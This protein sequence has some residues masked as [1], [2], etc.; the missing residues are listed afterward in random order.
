MFLTK[1]ELDLIIKICALDLANKQNSGTIHIQELFSPIS[2][3]YVFVTYYDNKFF[4]QANSHTD[5]FKEYQK[6]LTFKMIDQV[7]NVLSNVYTTRAICVELIESEITLDDIQKTKS[8][9]LM[10]ITINEIE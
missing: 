10:R 9:C 7:N 6:D 5:E 3:D 8:H 1:K 4:G 2:C